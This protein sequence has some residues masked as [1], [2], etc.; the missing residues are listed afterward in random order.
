[1]SPVS[2]LQVIFRQDDGH[3]AGV[4]EMLYRSD[5]FYSD[6]FKKFW[7]EDDDCKK[8]EKTLLRLIDKE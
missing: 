8:R 7:N 5:M 2:H 6:M 4:S 1:M 3:L